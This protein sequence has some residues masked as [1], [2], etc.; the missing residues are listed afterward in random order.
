MVL[1]MENIMLDVLK[2]K[3][4]RDM[5]KMLK[6]IFVGLCLTSFLSA[7]YIE[8]VNSTV[9]DTSTSTI[10]L[11][12]TN[13]NRIWIEAYSYCED[14]NLSGVDDWH[15]PSF[16]QLFILANRSKSNPA[17]SSKFQNVKSEPYWSSTTNMQDESQAWIVNFNDGSNERIDKTQTHYV[18]CFRK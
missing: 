9:Y 15:L 7:D 17:I 10:W 8:D 12:D 2:E 4:K 18:R 11:D 16:N 5:M 1:Q 3:S 6:F 13:T 14:L